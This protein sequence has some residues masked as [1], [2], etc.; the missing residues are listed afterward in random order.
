M[1]SQL[2]S[3]SAE[4]SSEATNTAYLASTSPPPTSIQLTFAPLFSSNS[5]T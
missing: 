5:G 4:E 1:A 3:T 2:I